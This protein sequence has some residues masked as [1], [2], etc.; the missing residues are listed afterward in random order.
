ML[1]ENVQDFF[2]LSM[3]YAIHM[4]KVAQLCQKKRTPRIYI[5]L[6]SCR[7]EGERYVGYEDFCKFLGIDEDTARADLITRLDEQVKQ[8]EISKKERNERLEKWENPYRKFT[9]VKSLILEPSRLELDELVRRG[10]IDFSFTYEPVYENDRKRGNPSKIHFKLIVGNLAVNLE[11]ERSRH[12]SN[13]VFI[14]TMLKRCGDFKVSELK[15]ILSRVPQNDLDDFKDYCYKELR[16]RIE[17]IQP[18][19]VAEYSYELMNDWLK[20]RKTQRQRQEQQDLFIPHDS[21][22]K[23][24]PV[25]TEYDAGAGIEKWKKLIDTYNGPAKSMLLRAEYLGLSSG[26]FYVRITEEDKKLWYSMQFTE[27]SELQ[28]LGRKILSLYGSTPSIFIAQN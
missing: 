11:E 8:G 20:K 18:D 9:K 24:T 14:N 21:V 3:G 23:T 22:T 25:E 2:N 7:D 6:S 5:F 13:R 19:N 1:K 17:Q 12:N 27:H 15:D 16:H 10:D 26:C 4:A 28:Q